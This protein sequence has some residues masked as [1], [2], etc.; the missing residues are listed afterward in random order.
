MQ[1]CTA[2]Q[3]TA[4]PIL[5]VGGLGIWQ[6]FTSRSSEKLYT[7]GTHIHVSLPKV[8]TCKFSSV[9]MISCVV[10][11]MSTDNNTSTSG[12]PCSYCYYRSTLVWTGNK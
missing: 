9:M 8:P 6:S 12:V 1:T 11:P 4:E 3:R 5:L 2:M 7:T 10:T